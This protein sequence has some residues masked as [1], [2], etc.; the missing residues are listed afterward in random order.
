M[1]R[2]YNP[3]TFGLANTEPFA[4]SRARSSGGSRVSVAANASRI[5]S[6]AVSLDVTNAR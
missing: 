2:S 6:R 1:N 4:P 5:Y 3:L